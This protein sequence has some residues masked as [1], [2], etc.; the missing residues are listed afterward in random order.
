MVA[1]WERAKELGCN[2]VASG[3]VAVLGLAVVA[4]L[5]LAGCY[6]SP[7]NYKD[8]LSG[9]SVERNEH[10]PVD[11]ITGPKSNWGDWVYSF[12]LL[13]STTDGSFHQVYVRVHRGDWLFIDHAYSH[14]IPLDLTLIDRTVGGSGEV[15]EHVAVNLTVDS[16]RKYAS[17]DGF[18]FELRGKRGRVT[19]DI[20]ASYF[21]AYVDYLTEHYPAIMGSSS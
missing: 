6:T 9:I 1:S 2:C 18:G 21:R 15:Y 3:I 20:P 17:G 7:D 16:L 10:G 13:R 4:V 19:V 5:G 11:W 14:G 12:F 8:V